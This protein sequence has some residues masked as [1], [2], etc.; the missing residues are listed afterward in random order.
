MRIN[1]R[2]PSTQKWILGLGLVFAA[3]YVYFNFV[4]MP[5]RALAAQL[6][7][8]IKHEADMLARGKR[9]AANF[10]TVEDDYN[11]MMASWNVAQN[12][13][14][15][16]R[17]MED[18]L[19]SVALEG[20]KH[21][22]DFL[23]FRPSDPIEKPFYWENAIQVKTLSNYH[24]LGQFLSSV[25]ALDRIV[26]ITDLKLT[27]FVPNKGRSPNTVEANF[28]ATIY[29]FK[30]LAATVRTSAGDAGRTATNKNAGG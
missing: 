21:N 4:Y 6:V 20:Q 8:D 11:R 19:K 30:E 15:S 22:V 12:L 25:A 10:Q 16:Q 29:I 2:N 18:L 14:P 1:L 5:R 24:D 17:E 23:L 13:L 26:N 27:A 9:I 7:K 28:T 3:T